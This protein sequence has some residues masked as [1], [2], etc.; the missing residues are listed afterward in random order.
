MD[1]SVLGWY[2]VR[3]DSISRKK[4]TGE[5]YVKGQYITS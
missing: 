3:K 5:N 1:D 4:V 2:N